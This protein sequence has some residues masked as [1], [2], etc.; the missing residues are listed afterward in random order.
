MGTKKSEEQNPSKFFMATTSVARFCILWLFIIFFISLLELLY[1]SVTHHFRES[2]FE[3][4]MWAWL[5]DLFFWFKALLFVYPLFVILHLISPKSTAVIYYVFG[6]LMVLIQFAF[7]LYFTTALVPLGADAYSYSSTDVKQTVGASGVIS[8][9][10]IVYIILLISI[11]VAGTVVCAQ[12]A[13]TK[14][15]RYIALLLPI[16]SVINVDFRYPGQSN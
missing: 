15:I 4:L 9:I 1:N 16:V 3:L 10:N 7:S 8:P 14:L 5:N 11:T 13:E 12:K 2:F 6:V